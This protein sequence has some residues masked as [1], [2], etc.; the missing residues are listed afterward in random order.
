MLGLSACVYINVDRTENSNGETPRTSVEAKSTVTGY[1]G[2]EGQ[3]NLPPSTLNEL[4]EK[5]NQG[6]DEYGVRFDLDNTKRANL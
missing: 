5:E 6:S 4:N 1:F 3:Q 2:E